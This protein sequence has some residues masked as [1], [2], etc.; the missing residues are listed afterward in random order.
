MNQCT[1]D[2]PRCQ[3]LRR[4]FSPW[5]SCIHGVNFDLVVEHTEVARDRDQRRVLVVKLHAQRSVHRLRDF[6]TASS[7]ILSA[8][9]SWAALTA[10]R[11]WSVNTLGFE[12]ITKAAPYGST[13]L[14]LVGP[15]LITA[16]SKAQSTRP[17]RLL[18][19]HAIG[20]VQATADTPRRACGQSGTGPKK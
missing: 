8:S 2:E 14:P 15:C 11:H 17:G 1:G 6:A 20:I 12:V 19:H 10:A 3:P 5:G 13:C 16:L 4:I 18:L 9:L 7:L